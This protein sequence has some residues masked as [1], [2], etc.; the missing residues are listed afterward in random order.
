[1]DIFESNTFVVYINWLYHERLPS[2]QTMIRGRISHWQKGFVLGDYLCDIDFQ[3]SV[4]DAFV[5]K[6]LSNLT[7]SLHW[8]YSRE[9]SVRAPDSDMEDLQLAKAFNFGERIIYFNVM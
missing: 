5:E 1:M 8:R 6:S 7:I 4:I 3:N 2:W 9:I